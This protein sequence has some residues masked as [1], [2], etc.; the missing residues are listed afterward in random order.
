MGKGVK[1]VLFSHK[2]SEPDKWLEE[3]SFP[4][5]DEVASFANRV[6]RDIATEKTAY[7][8][9]ITTDWQRGVSTN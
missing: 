6:R 9:N 1:E 7:I 2:E 5:I 8:S 4:G 3:S